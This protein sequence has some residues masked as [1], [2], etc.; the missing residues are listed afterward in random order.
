MMMLIS[1][2]QVYSLTSDEDQPIQIEADTAELDDLNHVSIYRGDVIA[3]QGSIR[4]TGD[5]L[6]VH[7]TDDNDMEILIIEGRP[8]TYRQLPENTD[9]YDEAKAIKMEYYE[10]KNMIILIDNAVVTQERSVFSGDRIEYDTVKNRV[11]A[12]SEADAQQPANPTETPEK[13]E[14]VKIIIK[15]KQE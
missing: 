8:A 14:R 6:T 10:L 15:P 11:K 2:Q 3:T 13:K 5:V 9:I 4:M 1:W 12:Y 7:F